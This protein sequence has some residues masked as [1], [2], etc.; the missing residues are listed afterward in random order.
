MEN[1][2]ISTNLVKIKKI[3]F[4]SLISMKHKHNVLISADW[5]FRKMM[6]C[7][8]FVPKFDASTF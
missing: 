1:T 3:P 2:V 7:P 8:P 5:L 6:K 4:N